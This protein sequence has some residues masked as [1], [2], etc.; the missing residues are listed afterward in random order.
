MNKFAAAAFLL[1]G[2]IFIPAARA[3]GTPCEQ[4]AQLTLPNTIITSAETVA[5]GAFTPPA[6]MAPWL[7]GDPKLFKRLPAFCRLTA[8]AKPTTDSN[9]KIE[10]WMP[11]TGWNGKFRGQGNGGFAG[12]IDYGSLAGAV[13]QGYATAA[14]DTGHAAGGTDASW[15]LGHPE[16]IVDFAYRG[17]HEMT[18]TGKA[19][20]KVFYGDAPQRAYFANC[21]DGGRE[22][23]MEA[24][25]FPDDYDGIL[26]GA[27]ANN[28]AHMVSS[29]V[30]V[31]QT[32]LRDPR[33]Y[34]SSLKL[35]AITRAALAACDA[36][37][38][39]TDG[40]I[41]D[42]QSCHFDPGVLLCKDGDSL[43]CLIA[44]QV[45]TLKKLYSGGVDSHGQSIFPGFVPGDEAG[46]WK[47][48]IL[49]SGPGGGGG[50]IYANK[51]FRYMVT[52]D[53]SWSALTANV[54]GSLR[55]AM[56]KTSKAVDSTDPDLSPF[57]AH[58]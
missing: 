48:W 34:I 53:T 3:A 54:D 56:E 1:V 36:Q 8:E 41:S 40:V 35:P 39:V 10:V 38:G 27:P 7:S 15:A 49:G 4:L 5:A 42:P 32:T 31:L 6:T 2:S 47:P 23:L 33:G 45:A 16:K 58:G 18:L 24:Q 29:G 22:A 19:V 17:I 11:V 25:R 37:D 43:S 46:S 21:S 13:A 28:W 52:G 30:D 57:A 9:I 12:E 51:Y 55:A 50:G 26:A 14:T 20:V 44:P